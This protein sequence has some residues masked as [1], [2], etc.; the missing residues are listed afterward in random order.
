MISKRR[1]F[2][3]SR[4]EVSQQSSPQLFAELVR[5]DVH[6]R[7][8]AEGRLAIVRDKQDRFWVCKAADDL[9]GFTKYNNETRRGWWLVPVYGPIDPEI[10][11]AVLKAAKVAA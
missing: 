4:F 10:Y 3:E 5:Y 2:W 11:K 8:M 7:N 6:M 1:A 9:D